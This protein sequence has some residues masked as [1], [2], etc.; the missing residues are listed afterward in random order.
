MGQGVIWPNGDAL[1]NSWSLA[2]VERHDFIGSTQDRALALA[3]DGAPPWTAV[4]AQNQSGGRGRRGQAWESAFG[5]GLWLS[6]VLP[7][8]AGE[9]VASTE[10]EVPPAPVLPIPLRIGLA[11]AEVVDD[12]LNA[13]GHAFGPVLVK[14]PNDVWVGGKKA[15][16]VL[17]ERRGPHTIVGIGLNLY[18]ESK[19]FGVEVSGR[20]TSLALEGWDG[21]PVELGA[22]LMAQ[23]RRC[24][25]EPAGDVLARLRPRDALFGRQLAAPDGRAGTGAGIDD[26]GALRVCADGQEWRVCA[27]TVKLAKPR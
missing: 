20:A 12:A 17:A 22:S 21:S 7:S 18:H 13:D 16:G 27:G 25:T 4:V 11:L 1:A 10:P 24:L 19:D 3:Q 26:T 2:H 5:L 23:V 8:E 6:L 9:V 15:A 14:W